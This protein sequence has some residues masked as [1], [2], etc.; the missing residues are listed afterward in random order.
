VTSKNTE[1]VSRTADN[2][3]DK[4][5][6]LIGVISQQKQRYSVPPRAV[7]GGGR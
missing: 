1:P 5:S 3:S 2:S 7:A 4:T 6:V